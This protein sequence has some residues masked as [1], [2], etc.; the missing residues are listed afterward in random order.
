M[1]QIG[2]Q[3][4]TIKSKFTELGTFETLKKVSDLGYH[5]IEISQ[6][7]MTPENVADMRRAQDELGLRMAAL[8]ASLTPQMGGTESLT[9]TFDKIVADCK[10]L[11][12]TMVRIGMLPFEAMGSLDLV[13][14]FAG[15]ADE[16]AKALAAEGIDLYYHNHHVEFAKFDGRFMLD[17]IADTAPDLGM[18]I[19]VHWAHRGGQDPVATLAQHAGRVKL[20]HLKDYRI[21]TMPPAVMEMIAAGDFAGVMGAFKDVVQFAEVGQG[22]LDWPAIVE[23]ALTSGAEYLFVEQDDTYGRDPFESLAMSR[24]HLVSLGYSHLF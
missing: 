22:T 9:T 24:D 5:A 12:T 6:V 14:D 13:V 10:A 19:D 7:P 4:S 1:A 17:V 15:R 8:S 23:Q 18:E 3:A 16:A 21:G 2:V 20:V 11:D